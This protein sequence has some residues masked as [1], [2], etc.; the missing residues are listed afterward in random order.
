MGIVFNL[1][2]QI[3]AP[4]WVRALLCLFRQKKEVAETSKKGD[5]YDR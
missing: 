5:K 4:T 1:A 2:T 3:T